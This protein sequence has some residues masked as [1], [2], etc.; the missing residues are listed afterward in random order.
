MKALQAMCKASP[1]D[2]GGQLRNIPCPVLVIEG[3]LDPDRA[4]P[5]AEGEKIVADLPT[6]LGELGVIEGAG[7]YPHAQTPDELLAL[8][9]PFLAKVLTRA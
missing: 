7:H 9:L 6:G 5:R 1:A 2:A 4:D 8:A 3:S